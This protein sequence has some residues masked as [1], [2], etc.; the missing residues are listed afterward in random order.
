MER[1]RSPR[2]STI[3]SAHSHWEFSVHITGYG[4]MVS[5]TDLQ[6][7]PDIIFLIPPGIMH[8]EESKQELDSIWGGFDACIPDAECDKILSLHSPE[9]VKKFIDCWKFSARNYGPI[10][11]ELDG[12]LKQ[13]VGRFFRELTGQNNLTPMQ[14]AVEYFNENYQTPVSMQE[15][16]EKLNCSPGYF[17]RQ[18]KEFTGETPVN[19]LN[20]IRLKRACFHLSHSTLAVKQIANLCGFPDPYYFS[21]IFKNTYGVSPLHY[22]EKMA[23]TRV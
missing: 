12:R 19:Y 3:D 14:K 17:Y 16:A 13:L 7:M 1:N 6:I 11:P 22:R 2:C 9:L 23:G 4:K 15:L 5:D 10:G 18:F 8:R 21:R 20:N